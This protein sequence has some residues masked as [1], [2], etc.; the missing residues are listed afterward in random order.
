[1]QREQVALA[2]TAAAVVER[3]RPEERAGA[4]NA[5]GP[6]FPALCTKGR[7][8]VRE[9]AQPVQNKLVDVNL[10]DGIQSSSENA[11]LFVGVRG[12]DTVECAEVGCVYIQCRRRLS[13]YIVAEKKFSQGDV[14]VLRLCANVDRER[15][16]ILVGRKEIRAL[17]LFA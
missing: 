11:A 3:K 17:P 8:K 16:E 15:K 4:Q 9:R 13:A 7:K 10:V 12:I 5:E 14:S 1:M 6:A 2:R